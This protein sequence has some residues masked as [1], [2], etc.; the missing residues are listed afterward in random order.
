MNIGYQLW[1]CFNFKGDIQ[2]YQSIV[3]VC[4]IDISE[5]IKLMVWC[6]KKEY[7]G[8]GNIKFYIKKVKVCDATV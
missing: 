8:G 7:V 5:I 2:H 1:Y 3:K 6:N 4:D